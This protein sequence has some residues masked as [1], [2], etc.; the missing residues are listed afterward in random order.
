MGKF[1]VFY[2]L[3]TM[4]CRALFPLKI[5]F[6]MAKIAEKAEILPQAIVSRSDLSYRRCNRHLI[7]VHVN[8]K[9]ISEPTK[10]L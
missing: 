9:P 5:G 7:L 8:D 6:T 3:D 4:H 2:S 10:K 1:A